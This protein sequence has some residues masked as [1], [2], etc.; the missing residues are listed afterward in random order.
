[1]NLEYVCDRLPF[2]LCRSIVEYV[3]VLPCLSNSIRSKVR[4]HF[5]RRY[6]RRCG[7]YVE[8]R[9]PHRERMYHLSCRQ[10]FYVP[11]YRNP[12]HYRIRMLSVRELMACYGLKGGNS[13]GDILPVAF[14]S[15]QPT[16]LFRIHIVST[17]KEVVFH[18]EYND[19]VV[20]IQRNPNFT[21]LPQLYVGELGDSRL[22]G[23]LWEMTM[24]SKMD[25]CDRFTIHS[26]VHIL[27]W[28]LRLFPVVFPPHR[29][30]SLSV[31]VLIP[32]LKR[33][34]VDVQRHL[35]MTIDPSLLDDTLLRFLLY[36]C[37]SL[38]ERMRESHIQC[39]YNHH[40]K[41]FWRFVRRRPIV[42]NYIYIENPNIEP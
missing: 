40:T 30:K 11:K 42:W 4:V 14:Y 36:R 21:V 28:M 35:G 10:K 33:M 27:Y 29:A 5:E 17:S 8:C 6:C 22:W 23:W 1:M 12:R 20:G 26:H 32:L 9:Y 41:W 24:V 25:L 7:E 31:E 39:L 34:P 2:V 13:L 19:M 16:W 38:L 3:G 37:P 15:P 18:Q